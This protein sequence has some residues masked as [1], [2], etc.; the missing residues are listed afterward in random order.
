MN[1]CNCH[2]GMSGVTGRPVHVGAPFQLGVEFSDWWLDTSF[3]DLSQILIEIESA[4][5]ASGYIAGQVKAYQLSGYVN[6]FVVIESYSG[7]EY[8]SDNH[9]KD[10]VLSVVAGIYPQ[11]N[12][13]SVTFQV[14]TYD[15]ATGQTQTIFQPSPI[16]AAGATTGAGSGFDAIGQTIGNVFRVD[17]TTGLVIGA[18]G[19][20]ALI[21][22]LKRL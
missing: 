6:P 14:E 4:L 1:G 2:A 21:L 19:A 3:K 18:V 7:R 12:F 16:A 22:L 17:A 10:A 13:G 11:V 5:S 15:P 20:V 9:L 8:G